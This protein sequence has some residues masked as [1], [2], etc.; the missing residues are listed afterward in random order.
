MPDERITFTVTGTYG[1]D[2]PPNLIHAMLEEI[3][4]HMEMYGFKDIQVEGS[5]PDAK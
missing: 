2:L 1:Y 5:F 3:T 4:R